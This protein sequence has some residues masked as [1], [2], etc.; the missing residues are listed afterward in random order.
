MNELKKSPNELSE[1]SQKEMSD[2]VEKKAQEARKFLRKIFS[3]QLFSTYKISKNM[4][5]TFFVAFLGLLY[6][7]NRHLAE[8]TVRDIDRLSKRVKNLGW[9]YKALNAELMKL[10][11]QTEIAKRADTLG[12]EERIVPPIKILV[13]DK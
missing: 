13:N 2:S 1:E 3:F 4:P 6:I 12:L 11:T 9:D 10:T 5:F 7:T 8:N